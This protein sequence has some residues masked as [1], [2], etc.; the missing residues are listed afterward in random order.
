MKNGVKSIQA[1]AC[2]GAGMV[3]E[4]ALA[5]VLGLKLK[6]LQINSL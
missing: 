2:N 3:I 5:D 4:F 6:S 1:A